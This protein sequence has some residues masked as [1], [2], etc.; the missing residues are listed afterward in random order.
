LINLISTFQNSFKIPE[1]RKKII[2][3]LIL[4]GVYRIGSHI[5]LPGID[6]IT[7]S[8]WFT[9]QAGGILGL[10]SFILSLRFVAEVL[11]LDIA[12]E[13]L[14]EIYN[15]CCKILPPDIRPVVR[16]PKKIGIKIC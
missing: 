3:T 2:Y 4:L 13:L 12:K 9:S 8:N 10:Y 5:P 6:I 16:D 1:L 14:K 15:R 11:G 7:L